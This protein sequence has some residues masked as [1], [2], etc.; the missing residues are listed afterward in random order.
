REPRA[1][2]ARGTALRGHLELAEQLACVNSAVLLRRRRRSEGGCCGLGR[3]ARG[4]GRWC[5]RC[6]DECDG[7]E[8]DGQ[9]AEHGLNPG[10]KRVLAWGSASLRAPLTARADRP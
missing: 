10:W 2:I 9:A 3:R 6:R 5:G 1:L 4:G 7:G 8:S